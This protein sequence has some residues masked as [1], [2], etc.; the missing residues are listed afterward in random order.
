MN[1][2]LKGVL[3]A[4]PLF[5]FAG[6]CFDLWMRRPDSGNAVVSSASYGE[7]ELAPPWMPPHWIGPFMREIHLESRD[8]IFSDELGLVASQISDS[9]WVAGVQRVRRNYAGD[10]QLSIRIRRPLCVLHRQ[11]KDH[12][13]LDGELVELPLLSPH[14]PHELVSVRLPEVHVDSIV[15]EDGAVRRRWLSELIRFI[16][17]WNAR[18]EMVERLQVKRIDLDPYRSGPAKECRLRVLVK[19][20]RFK[21][22]V[23][24][25]WGVHREFNE[26]EGRRSDEKWSDL[27]A[28]IG[29]DRP[30]SSLDL[31]YKTPDINY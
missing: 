4:L 8:S 20:L 17:E 14:R 9:P 10:V 7:K 24:I 28:A 15:S 12:R 29:Q 6:V 27:M 18:P 19:D 23:L 16:E 22:D 13:Y 2:W 31:R 30:F 25:E 5:L 1:P 26:L 11:G 21:S 3:Q